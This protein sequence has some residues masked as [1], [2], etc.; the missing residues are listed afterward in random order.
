MSKR[1]GHGEGSIHQRADGLWCAIADLGRGANGKR[2][3]KYIYG[4]T[5]KEVAD[6]LNLS[7]DQ[8]SKIQTTLDGQGQSMRDAMQSLG[9]QFGP[10]MSDEDRQKIRSKFQEVQTATDAKVNA[11]LTADQKTKFEAMKGAKFTFPQGRG[12]GQGG[13]RRRNGQGAGAA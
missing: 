8:R 5:R 10:N 1:R 4:K 7:A 6:Q 12:F 9:I 13:G 2:K 11:I 3:R